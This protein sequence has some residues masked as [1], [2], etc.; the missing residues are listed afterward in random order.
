MIREEDVR[1]AIAEMQGQ[2]NP[3]AN[4]CIKL[5]AYYTILDHLTESPA[6][7]PKAYEP[8]LYSGADPDVIDYDG[9]SDF[10]KAIRGKSQRDVMFV[11]W[12]HGENIRNGHGCFGPWP[13]FSFCDQILDGDAEH[14]GDIV[15]RDRCGLVDWLSPLLVI[16][17]GPEVYAGQH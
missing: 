11:F 7:V 5:A 6:P 15:D 12:C 4:T 1:E 17:Q 8:E 10:A 9:D 16:L 13:S 14:L 3:N 2:K